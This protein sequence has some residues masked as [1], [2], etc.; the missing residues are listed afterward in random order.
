VASAVADLTPY[1]PRLAARLEGDPAGATTSF[2]GSLVC[3][4]LSG[5]TTLAERLAKR[6][7][8]GAEEL[9][10][11]VNSSF[12][13][14]LGPALEAGGDVLYFGGDSA[15]IVFT[16]DDHAGR[17]AEAAAGMQR[18]L[19]TGG[20]LT[21]SG[22]TV[23]LRMSIGIA[24]GVLTAVVAGSAQRALVLMGD[25]AAAAVRLE[26]EAGAARVLATPASA[27]SAPRA[28]WDKETSD[29]RWRELRWRR[30]GDRTDGRAAGPMTNSGLAPSDVWIPTAL[31]GQLGEAPGQG[32]VR[33]VTTAFVK[34]P[35]LGVDVQAALDV[36]DAIEA[37]AAEWGVCWLATDLC[38]GGA[39]FVLTAGA[40]AATEDDEERVLR[41]TRSIMDAAPRGSVQAGIEQGVVFAGD[42]GHPVRR[43]WTVMGDSVNVAARLA[44][45]AAPGQVLAGPNVVAA[46]PRVFTGTSRGPLV[47]KGRRRAVEVFTVEDPA[48]APA[49]R[50]AARALPFLG[51]TVELDHLQEA[52][53]SACQGHGRAIEIVGDAG[54]GKSRLLDELTATVAGGRPRPDLTVVRADPYRSSIPYSTA[55]ALV[56]SVAG[57]DVDATMADAGRALHA[58]VRS[59]APHLLP[60]L[61][62]VATA[63]DATTPSTEAVDRLDPEQTPGRRHAAVV[64][65]LEAARPTPWFLVVE[66]LHWVD[67]ATRSLLSALAAVAPSQ[68]WLLCMTRRSEAPA[69]PEEARAEVLPLPPL[70]PDLAARLVVA[71]A[72]PAAISDL[73]LTRVVDAAGGNALFLEQ[74]A[75]HT[76][77]EDE[78]LPDTVERVLAARIDTLRPGARQLLRDTS[79]VGRFA[80]MSMLAELLD[81]PD[82]ALDDR[83]EELD[84]FVDVA[85][86]SVRFRNDL[87]RTVAYRGLPFARRRALHRRIADLVASRAGG[88]GTLDDDAFGLLAVH[89]LEAGDPE[90]AW[91]VAVDAARRAVA[92]VALADAADLYR[93]ALRVASGVADL[94]DAELARVHEE[95]GDVCGHLGRFEDALAAYAAASRLSHDPLD[96]ARLCIHRSAIEQ[97]RGELRR[98]LAW[99]SRGLRLIDGIEGAEARRLRVQ[100]ALEQ[101]AARH[102]QG[103]N[104]ESLRWAEQAMADARRTRDKRLRALTCLHLEIA[105]GTLADGLARRYGDEAICLFEEVDDRK[106]LG[107]ALVNSGLTAYNEGRWVDA[108]DSYERAAKVVATTGNVTQAA[109]VNVNTAFLLAD[110]GEVAEAAA[111]IADAGRVMRAGG[112]D[113]FVGY[114]E[115]LESRLALWERDHAEARRLLDT[116]AGRFAAHDA[117]QMSL[118]CE[119][120]GVE[121]LLHSG[122]AAE[123]A[124]EAE[125]LVGV[126][127]DFG[128]AELLPITIRRLWARALLRVGDPTAAESVARGALALAR[129]NEARFEIALCLD[130]IAHAQLAQGAPVE[131]AVFAERDRLLASLGVRRTLLPLAR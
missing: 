70:E 34:A 48:G 118:D 27:E 110:Q 81:D 102:Y 38:E 105:H 9:T 95:H 100:L 85:F 62:L 42:V 80:P 90:R 58:W 39:T 72:E 106:G 47:V 91:P 99:G 115:W 96:R 43:S 103:R 25:T 53:R 127:D 3:A 19:S 15:N 116:A 131:P 45:N 114:V 71:A 41:A 125:R 121:L 109:V 76:L 92:R 56:R 83:W 101:S 7:Q 60:W 44:S 79:A 1:V 123:A 20:R 66:D 75:A 129:D 122:Q 65:L 13:A 107:D 86:E 5:F 21:W 73:M 2:P 113:V 35:R 29:S 17:A 68:R 51:R 63:S 26:G 22:G 67:E 36:V 46:S 57:I 31:R 77:R 97:K 59:T 126:I 54:I 6:G 94:P 8:E 50:R 32:E 88:D 128:P 130:A 78:D 49:P 28:P 33:R 98:A 112:H 89:L 16:D 10:A 69:L 117:R 11:L 4:D 119:V 93:R 18:A 52:W 108:R 104:R 74:L 30:G 87:S 111:I 40:P 14:I 61:P 37:G 64:E 120:A 24:T 12:A 23:R 55:A 82:L 124:T 84:P